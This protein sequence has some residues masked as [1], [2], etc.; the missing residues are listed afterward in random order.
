MFKDMSQKTMRWS[1]WTTFHIRIP[2]VLPASRSN[3]MSD[4][5]SLLHSCMPPMSWAS[6]TEIPEHWNTLK[7]F[8][9]IRGE[10]RL[11]SMVYRQGDDSNIK[12]GADCAIDD[13][14]VNDRK[15]Q[16]YFLVLQAPTDH[17]LINKW[18]TFRCCLRSIVVVR[19]EYRQF[20][21]ADWSNYD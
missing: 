13:I 21:A 9:Y 10:H 12:S 8:S 1:K 16:L 14:D 7:C 17:C 19:S 18:S 20:Q 6:I 4:V 5:P 11:A 15:E 2:A 3:W